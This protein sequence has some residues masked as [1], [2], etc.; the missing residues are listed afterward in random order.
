M[1]IKKKYKLTEAQIHTL[2][3]YEDGFE[4]NYCLPEGK[5]RY[6][7][8]SAL[9]GGLMDLGPDPVPREPLDTKYNVHHGD[10]S[11]G[12]LNILLQKTGIGS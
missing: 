4:L 9:E 2:N 1:Q 12:V 7:G 5:R 3:V 10:R 8:Y 11:D 6:Y